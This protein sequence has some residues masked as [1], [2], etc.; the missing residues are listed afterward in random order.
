[1]SLS[2]VGLLTQRL[3]VQSSGPQVVHM[4]RFQQMY[5]PF[6]LYTNIGKTKI[7]KQ[8]IPNS[9]MIQGSLRFV[10]LVEFG[11]TLIGVSL[12]GLTLPKSAILM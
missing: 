10:L 5:R 8:D 2:D 4:R 6:H 12:V 11:R 1:M 7:K 3:L 9:M